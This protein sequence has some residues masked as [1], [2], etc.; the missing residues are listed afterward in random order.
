MNDKVEFLKGF[1]KSV[2]CVLVEQG[3]VGFGRPCVGILDPVVECYLDINPFDYEKVHEDDKWD[4]GYI[5]EYNDNLSA[6]YEQTPDAYHK[7]SCMAVLVHGDNYEEGINQLYNW[8]KNILSHGEVKLAKHSVND[9]SK[10]TDPIDLIFTH[11]YQP[12]LIYKG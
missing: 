1:A 9:L 5:F 3:E 4:D 12:A 11:A 2:D 8:V 6:D 10:I 7:H